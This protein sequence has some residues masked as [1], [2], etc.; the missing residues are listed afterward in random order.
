MLT[1]FPLYAF[2]ILNTPRIEVGS[3]WNLPLLDLICCI[4]Q[5]DHSFGVAYKDCMIPKLLFIA[6]TYRLRFAGILVFCLC[7]FFLFAQTSVPLSKLP[8]SPSRTAGDLVY[9]SGQ[10]ARTPDGGD[11]K[12]SVEAETRQVMENIGRILEKNGCSFDDVV[13]ATVYL[14]D[15]KDYHAMNGVYASFF[16]DQF[17]ARACIGGA[18]LVFDFRV[19]ISCVAYKPR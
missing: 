9:I 4:A 18:E 17:P 6:R 16:K 11:V 5:L 7:A 19:E 8:F 3:R 15:I 14:K 12:D 2:S 13:N 1:V 10:I